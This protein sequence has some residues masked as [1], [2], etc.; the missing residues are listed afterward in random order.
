[1]KELVSLR[2]HKKEVCSIAW[3]P[4]HHNY[5][6]SGG[7]EGSILHWSTDSSTPTAAPLEALDFAHDSNVWSLAFHP[8]GH[9][10]ASASNDHTTRFWSRNR[11]GVS[12][13]LMDR[14]H[15]GKDESRRL[16]V[17]EE[18]DEHD[19]FA[20]PGLGGPPSGYGQQRPNFNQGQMNMQNMNMNM[21][22]GMNAPGPAVIPGFGGPPGMD[23]MMG[24]GMGM[25]PMGF[26]QQQ[27]Q[28]G[29]RRGGPLADQ[30][31]MWN[32]GDD[33]QGGGRR[34]GRGRGRGRGGM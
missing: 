10:L 25:P 17:K 13:N 30:R 29:A 33:Q 19:E 16:G 27:Q 5:L 23:Q 24:M 22:L 8:L 31:D 21:G 6:A 12:R 2:G 34:R 9:V 3:H 26:Q 11:P 32:P 4:I 1:M 18:E 15:I 7:S 20:L 28:Y 14:F